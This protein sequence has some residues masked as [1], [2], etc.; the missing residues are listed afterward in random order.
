MIDVSKELIPVL[1]ELVSRHIEDKVPIIIGG[2]FISP[3]LTK[4]FIN[5]EVKSIFLCE[6]DTNQIVQNYLSRE[7]GDLQHF[8]YY[9]NKSLK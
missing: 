8:R 7:G 4:S 3:E 1:K 6:T 2:D 5:S 9:F